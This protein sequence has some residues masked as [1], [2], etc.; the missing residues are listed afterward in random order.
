MKC[1]L[2]IRKKRARLKALCAIVISAGALL[3][4][5]PK[6][7]GAE[8][9]RS[10]TFKEAVQIALKQ[11]SDLKRSENSATLNRYAV[12]KAKLDFFPDLRL[13]LSGQESYGRSFSENEGRLLNET[14]ESFN[15]RV[16]SSLVLFDGLANISG[17]R[18]ARL[19]ESAGD[20]DTER[21]RQTVVFDVVSGYI[22][23]IEANEQMHVREENL[24]AQEKLEGQVQVMVDEG[25]RP[26]SDLYQQQAN[27]ASARLSL[28]DARR[29][30]ELSRVDLVQALQLDPSEEYD[31]E[32]PQLPQSYTSEPEPELKTILSRAFQLRHDLRG[33]EDRLEAAVQDERVAGAGYWPTVTF[34]AGYGSNYSST[35]DAGF[36]D[37]LDM[38]RSGSLG[39]GIS[40]PVFDRNATKRAKQ[41]ARI[42]TDNVT[43]ALGD[44]RQQV[45]LQVRRALLDWKAA[46][47]GLTA[48][49]AQVQAAEQALD[50]VS[51]RYEAGA[52]TLYE[53]TLSRA[54]LV[55]A[56]SSKVSASYNLLWQKRL[57]DYYVGDLDPTG[58][59]AP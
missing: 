50:A 25:Q 4:W 59:L 26:I 58:P 2:L 43:I 53:V 40:M 18:G 24:A 27:V 1:D 52:A 19:A 46:R 5:P 15:G 3:T 32:I 57:L 28:V 22:A 55:A 29:T 31:F 36:M 33:M 42:A 37:Q 7:A 35:S 45:A 47:E 13:S 8:A 56:T 44:L 49:D 30:F 17:L 14:T 21:T 51:A 34:S 54:D 23:L 38:R 10:I 16:S 20:L 39:I 48:A 6:S 12:S 9:A 41:Q 11:N